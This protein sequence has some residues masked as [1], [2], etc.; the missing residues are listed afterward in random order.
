MVTSVEL[1]TQTQNTYTVNSNKQS[2]TTSVS[3]EDQISTVSSFNE[4]TLELSSSLL[5]ST[6]YSKSDSKDVSS[7]SLQ[8][9]LDQADLTTQN[10][11]SLVEKVILKQTKNVSLAALYGKN[12]AATD[13]T[14]VEQA[15]M[16][17]SEDGEYGV[18]AVSDRIVDFAIKISGGD[19]AKL[20]ELKDAIKQG[21]EEAG[22][23]WGGD[24]PSISQQTYDAIMK[25]LDDWAG[26]AST[27]TEQ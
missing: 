7:A 1:L 5:S 21:F 4:D 24:L 2:Q 8:D 13:T 3:T 14:A 19:T 17:V 16:S 11:K 15:A 9:I 6:V 22:V 27:A 25:K 20:E 18:E 23:E 10:L 12:V 26:A